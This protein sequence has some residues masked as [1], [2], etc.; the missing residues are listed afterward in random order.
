V[1]TI[2]QKAKGVF[3]DLYGTLFILG[4]MQ[5]AWADWMDALYAELCPR[6]SFLSRAAFEDCC[7]QFFGKEQPPHADDGLTIFER[8]IRRL[9][10]SL[11]LAVEIPGLQGAAARATNA[12]Q[13]HVRIDPLA[14]EVLAALKQNKVLAMIS[15]FD[16]PV[17]AH[18][19]IREAGLGGFFQTIVVSGEVGV[20]KP[21]PKIFHIAL[22]RT[23]LS[24][25]E[26]VYV[27]DTQEDVE[28]ATAAGIRP[29]LIVR[30]E[31]PGEP[32][33]LDY[34]RRG[35]PMPRPLAEVPSRITITSLQEVVGLVGR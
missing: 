35:E 4:N 16:H 8:R 32:R 27:G 5:Q 1:Q 13:A 14:V 6:D 12:W 17:H 19:V 29:I 11:G 33:L 26:V 34:T 24:A 2:L 9:T 20:K 25:E 3:F 23:G 7:H 28:G 15:N 10:A 31:E 30:P 21:D 22:D 18:R